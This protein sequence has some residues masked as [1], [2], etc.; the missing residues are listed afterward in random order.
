MLVARHFQ[1]K[2]EAFFRNTI[3]DGQLCKTK[4]YALH[5]ELQERGI[6]YAHSFL[7]IFNPL[8]SKNEAAYIDFT[9]KIIDAQWP[10]P[11]NDP[12]LFELV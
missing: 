10:D 6:P 2:A 11:L 4:Y 8:N 9:E 3:L 5:I 12:K 1:Y 7:W